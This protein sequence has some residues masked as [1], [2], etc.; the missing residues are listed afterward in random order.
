MVGRPPAMLSLRC[1]QQ[2]E[3]DIRLA[4]TSGSRHA[5]PTE[6]PV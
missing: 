3:R 5:P 6:C 1:P 4:W 2:A